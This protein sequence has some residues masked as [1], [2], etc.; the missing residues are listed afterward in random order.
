MVAGQVVDMETDAAH[1]DEKTVEYIH[2]CKTGAL[3]ASSARCGAI[4]AEAS[5]SLQRQIS[6]YGEGVGMAF[7]II[8]DVLDAVGSFG[9][10]KAGANLDGER[11]KATYPGVFGLERAKQTA[12][13][14]VVEAKQA[15]SDTGDRGLAL[16]SLADLVV[17]R[18]H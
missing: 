5:A 14:L 3:I 16:R 7:Q 17:S 15:I 1:A 8:D 9:D 12:Q 2:S 4:A 13:R 11:C 10:L 6:L 18:S